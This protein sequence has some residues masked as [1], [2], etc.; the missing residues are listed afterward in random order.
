[1]KKLIKKKLYAEDQD[2]IFFEKALS[3]YETNNLSIEKQIKLHE[4]KEIISS[5]QRFRKLCLITK[6]WIEKYMELTGYDQG[7]A[8]R[9]Y[10]RVVESK[11]YA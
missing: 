10:F 5:E 2:L 11:K 3:Q 7:T 8:E 6:D 9:D 4:L 1:M